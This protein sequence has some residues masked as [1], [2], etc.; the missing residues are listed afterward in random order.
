M[1]VALREHAVEAEQ[2]L[3]GVAGG[4]CDSGVVVVHA[5]GQSGAVVDEVELASE[6]RWIGGAGLVGEIGEHGPDPGPELVGGLLDET[7]ARCF[8]RG[9]DEGAAVEVG[10][11][12]LLRLGVED[13]RIFWRGS[14]TPRSPR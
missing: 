7:A 5:A 14:S 4:R 8:G 1:S 9:G 6:V 10:L 12:V 11:L 2:R 13:A 3:N